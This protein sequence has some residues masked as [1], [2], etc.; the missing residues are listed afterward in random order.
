MALAKQPQENVGW[1][2]RISFLTYEIKQKV[3]LSQNV[4]LFELQKHGRQ[5]IGIKTSFPGNVQYYWY[6]REDAIRLI[7]TLSIFLDLD[8]GHEG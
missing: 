6:R 3:Q 1:L 5:Y 7:D 8:P 2:D 4:F